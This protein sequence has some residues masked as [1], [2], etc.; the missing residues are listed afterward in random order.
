MLQDLSQA[1]WLQRPGGSGNP[2]TYA[3]RPVQPL[4]RGRAGRVQYKA[5]A[6]WSDRFSLADVP[7]RPQVAAAVEQALEGWEAPGDHPVAFAILHLANDGWYLLLTRF[8]NANNL[9]HRVFGV[10]PG[11]RGSLHAVPLADPHLIAC[12]WETRLIKHEVDAWIDTVLAP[13][14]DQLTAASLDRY[15]DR[16]FQGSL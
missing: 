4:G 13:P 12:V 1:H 14:G 6:M 15:L 10:A 2:L 7:G 8:N 16:Q 3:P 9:R 11:D 5:Y